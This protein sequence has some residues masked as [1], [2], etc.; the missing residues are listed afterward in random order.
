MAI[1]L[2]AWNW[3]RTIPADV[4]A[5][6]TYVGRQ[7]CARCHVSEHKAWSGSDHDRAMALATEESVLGDFQD[8]SFEY[9]GV[10]TRFF[11]R[12]EKFLVNTEGPDGQHHDYEVKYTFGARPLQ[13][14]MVE[15]PDGRV[16]VL[17]EAWDVRNRRW[18]YVVPPDVPNERIPPG[19]P[20]HWT[21]I[22]QNWNSTCA[23]CHSTNVHKNYEVATNTY[24][25]TWEEINVS[26]EECHG[27]GSVHVELAQRLSPFWDRQLGFG[28]TRLQDKNT[29][30]QLEMCAKCHARR[31][32]VHEE[33]RPGRPF[34][35]HYV[36]VTLAEGL[37]QA[38]GQ[39][40]DEV[41]EYD[42]FLQSKM[43]ANRVKC[44]DCHE[45]HSLKLRFQGNALCTQCHEAHDPAKYDT[46]AHHHHEVGTP[47]AQCIQCH[48][49]T[50]TYMVIDERRDHSFRVPRPDLSALLGTTNACNNCHTK[51]Q[52]THEWAANAIR[53]WYGENSPNRQLPHWAPAIQA[54][55]TAQPEGEKRLLE[56][57]GRITTPILVRA[58]AIELLANYPSAAS[59]R[60]R[61]E[62]L[63]AREPLLRLSAIRSL[64][65]D[66]PDRI[67]AALAK[68]IEDPSRAVRIE[69]A[70]RLAY[71][72]LDQ[73]TDRQRQV[74]EQTMQEYRRSVELALDHA[75]GHLSLA[76]LDRHHGRIDQAMEHL[77]TAIKLEPYL[78]GARGELASIMEEQGANPA[79]IRKLRLEEADLLER[80]AKLA[81]DHA[82]IFH[83]LGLLRYL[84]GDPEPADAALRRACELAPRNY[85]FRMALALLQLKRYETTG[86]DKRLEAAAHS[87]KRLTE[88]NRAD[89]RAKEIFLDLMR[90]RQQKEQAAKRAKE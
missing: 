76:S 28:L 42:S 19:D 52:E 64:P 10:V 57:L 3:W 50:R 13:Q 5:N 56:L 21:G 9:Q 85:D 68:L 59:A 73:L 17:R 33:F 24:H 8:A 31:Y 75:A 63:D 45:P 67:V 7:T 43:Y 6:P 29:D 79:E 60:A 4:A 55:R 23:D 90:I 70:L 71:L 49:P 11:R 53:T 48:M 82:E 34:L 22:G 25:T 39:I 2:L 18:F 36:P 30:T 14:Y 78:T 77:T 1:G 62:A 12:G 80:D 41:Y 81:P 37:Y 86:D 89:P 15:F 47:G 44:T 66:D 38:D 65:Q 26:C 61:Q 58:T 88:L 69:A 40:W 32:Q 54:G 35:D 87:I 46:P 20:L 83:R 27:P 74:F 51:P 16:Q 84:L 72:P